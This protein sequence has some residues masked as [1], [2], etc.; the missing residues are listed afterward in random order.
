M[1]TTLRQ[2]IKRVMQ[3]D[4]DG[5]FAHL[6]VMGDSSSMKKASV[7]VVRK[8]Y[9]SVIRELLAFPKQRAGRMPICVREV[10][11][12]GE[13]SYD[14]AFLNPAYIQPPK[15][16]KPWGGKNPPKGHYNCNANKFN[17]Y[18][19]FGYTEWHK[20]IDTE[21]RYDNT[22]TESQVLAEILWELTFNGWTAAACK[23]AVK[24]LEKLLSEAVSEI[25]DNPA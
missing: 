14:V 4:P 9:S 7:E 12:Q 16:L 1:K 23:K 22:L 24:K 11:D 8:A 3:A 10:T 18:F 25:K 15:G 19:S 13:K 5:V 21:V 17:Q 20:L 2:L 6:A